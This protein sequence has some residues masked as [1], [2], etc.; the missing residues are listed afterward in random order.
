MKD[1]FPVASPTRTMEATSFAFF[2]SLWIKAKSTFNLSAIDVTLPGVG[3]N[4]ELQN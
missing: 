2:L 4:V 1:T 3:E